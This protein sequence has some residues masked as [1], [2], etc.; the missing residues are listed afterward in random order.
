MRVHAWL[1][2]QQNLYAQAKAGIDA[3]G[4]AVRGRVAK[5]PSHGCDIINVY[6]YYY[7]VEAAIVAGR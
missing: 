6:Y 2:Q 3:A 5:W 1:M 4:I 7:C